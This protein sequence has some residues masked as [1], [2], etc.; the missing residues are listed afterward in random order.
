M[1][2][3]AC[4]WPWRLES[5]CTLF[6]SSGVSSSA[7]SMVS[8]AHDVKAASFQHDCACSEF[9]V[10][11]QSAAWPASGILGCTAACSCPWHRILQP[12]K[13]MKDTTSRLAPLPRSSGIDARYC[14]V[15]KEP[16]LAADCS[17]ES[18]E[19]F[20]FQDDSGRLVYEAKAEQAGL[21]M[22]FAL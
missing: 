17:L 14:P 12:G 4:L 3:P 13:T 22:N 18:S 15:R 21:T 2:S 7:V 20:F 11:V 9:C 8:A 10:L 19:H 1:R 16:R 5:H 6:A